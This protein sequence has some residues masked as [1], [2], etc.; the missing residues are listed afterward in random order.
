MRDMNLQISS[1][2]I[3][4]DMLS[5]GGALA[6]LQRGLSPVA[7]NETISYEQLDPNMLYSGYR[8]NSP[9][10]SPH[11][12]RVN[13]QKGTM[14]TQFGNFL[15]QVDAKQ[16]PNSKGPTLNDHQLDQY[17]LSAL[18]NQL[19]MQALQASNLPPGINVNG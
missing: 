3:P 11:S 4:E 9:S 6:L 8:D 14:S 10:L 19:H 1:N 12:I 2:Q 16:F 7:G 13:A 17:Q 18:K 5:N 15:Y